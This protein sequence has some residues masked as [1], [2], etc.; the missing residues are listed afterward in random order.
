M[1]CTGR[2]MT[3]PSRRHNLNLAI[4]NA[5]VCL[6]DVNNLAQLLTDARGATR[7]QRVALRLVERAASPFNPPP[8][9]KLP[10]VLCPQGRNSPPSLLIIGNNSLKQL[11]LGARAR[12]LAAALRFALRAHPT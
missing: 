6:T 3:V 5:P 4:A 1:T 2:I 10:V 9:G 7:W 12:G 11:A 8:T